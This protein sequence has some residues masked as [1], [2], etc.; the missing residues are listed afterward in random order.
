MLAPIIANMIL[1][2]ILIAALNIVVYFSYTT[3][4]EKT[5][6]QTESANIVVDL[7]QDLKDILTESQMKSLKDGLTPLLVPPNLSK[8]DEEVRTGNKKLEIQTFKI[9]VV[10]MLVG[11][12][13]VVAMSLKYDFKIRDFLFHNVIVLIS[14]V[15]VEFIFLTFYVKNYITIDSNFVKN[16]IIQCLI[17]AGK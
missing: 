15:I 6:V 11:L 17:D 2:I 8:D 7:T 9:M 12:I 14:V 16:K 13:V 1:Q 3:Y 4:I 10:L 5:I